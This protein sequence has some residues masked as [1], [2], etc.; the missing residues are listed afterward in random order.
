M[1]EPRESGQT[2]AANTALPAHRRRGVPTIGDVATL[3]GVSIGTVSKS[4][5][6]RQGVSNQTRSKV[7]EAAEALGFHSTR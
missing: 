4:L 2:A 7:R 1:S 3:A 5:N 6:G